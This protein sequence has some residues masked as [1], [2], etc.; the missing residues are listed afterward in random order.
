[1]DYYTKYKKYKNKY[2]ELKKYYGGVLYDNNILK[3]S[4]N[5]YTYKDFNEID[6]SL[7]HEVEMLKQYKEY[8]LESLYKAAC[9]DYSIDQFKGFIDTLWYTQDY[10]CLFYISLLM[11][12][13]FYKTDA[14]VV[15][16]GESPNKIIFVQSLFYDNPI[17]KELIDSIDSY[18]KNLEF[19]Y[20]P[21]S[22]VSKY[23]KLTNDFVDAIEVDEIVRI[24]IETLNSEFLKNIDDTDINIL[25]KHINYFKYYQMDAKNIADRDKPFI[26]V[27]RTETFNTLSSLIYIFSKMYNELTPIEQHKFICNFQ[28][29]GIDY[30]HHKRLDS[31]KYLIYIYK[32]IEKLFNISY[33]NASKMFKFNLLGN[34]D[35]YYM[36]NKTKLFELVNLNKTNIFLNLYI[37]KRILNYSSAPEITDN[38]YRCV[39][40][41][42]V[43]KKH[44]EEY[45]KYNKYFDINT[46]N[47]CNFINYITYL[48]FNRMIN[49]NH[50]IN[51]IKYLEYINQE[52]LYI[53]P[54]DKLKPQN[55]NY[56]YWNIP[57]FDGNS[58]YEFIRRDYFIKTMLDEEFSILNFNDPYD[59]PY[60]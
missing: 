7:Q 24:Q 42:D 57:Y 38:S 35:D 8:V 43:V 12:K 1:M 60:N 31:D 10:Y 3:H 6:K 15:C 49:K 20:L 5:I 39:K 22:G 50:H 52:F 40:S 4:P 56:E 23:S 48:I 19:T 53:L 36:Y 11:I 2:L 29:V 44:D 21:L 14:K 25:T 37:S 59:F 26:F 55:Y 13:Y 54:L 58:N 30:M 33:E 27:D 34:Y 46:D 41:Y 45:T 17:T 28:I 18:P 51:L 16:L 9:N 32:L 47:N